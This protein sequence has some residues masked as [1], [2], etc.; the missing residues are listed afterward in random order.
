MTAQTSEGLRQPSVSSGRLGIK[1]CAELLMSYFRRLGSKEVE[2]VK[3]YGHPGV[4]AYYDAGA[5][6][7]LLDVCDLEIG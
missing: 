2:L 5:Y 4:W 6:S 7:L 1:E 3:T